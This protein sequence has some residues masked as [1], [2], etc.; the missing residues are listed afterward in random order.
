MKVAHHN[1]EFESTA[2]EWMQTAM[3]HEQEGSLEKAAGAYEKV[4]KLS[5][6]NEQAYNRL[7]IV[8]RKLKDYEKEATVI[9]KAIREFETLYNRP[10]KSSGKKV[11]QLSK[12]LMKLTG[13]ADKKGKL[14]YQPE[15]L[16]KWKK[17]EAVVEKR[18]KKE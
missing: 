16:G 1:K 10:V 14:L 12:Q 17:R 15:P 18:L 3:Q 8:Y 13:L 7:M 2:G 4:I 5:K 6:H 11:E 9:R